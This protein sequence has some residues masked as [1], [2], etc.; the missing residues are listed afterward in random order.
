MKK[1]SIRV[2]IIAAAVAAAVLILDYLSA[3][4]VILLGASV[5]A[6]TLGTASLLW[7]IPAVRSL[8]LAGFRRLYMQLKT[9]RI[10]GLIRRNNL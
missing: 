2:R 5:F 4:R 8:V 9:L 3:L 6:I 10:P 7:D 1:I